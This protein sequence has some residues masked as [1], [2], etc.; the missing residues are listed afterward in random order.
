MDHGHPSYIGTPLELQVG[1]G[2]LGIGGALDGFS[3]LDVERWP[4]DVTDVAFTWSFLEWLRCLEP[5]EPMQLVE[6]G[7]WGVTAGEQHLQRG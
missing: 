3:L 1:G 5:I 2:L 7:T 6:L 4:V